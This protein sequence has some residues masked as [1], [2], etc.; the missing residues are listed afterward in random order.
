LASTGPGRAPLLVTPRGQAWT[1]DDLG[2]RV[3]ALLRGV[4]GRVVSMHSLRHG[5]ATATLLRWGV[6]E[7]RAS[8]PDAWGHA[9]VA[10]PSLA[11]VQLALGDDD[12]LVLHRLSRICGHAAPGVTV[13]HYL[14]MDVVQDAWLAESAPVRLRSSVAADLLQCSAPAMYQHLRPVEHGWVGAEDVLRAQL[15]RLR[16][17]HC[18]SHGER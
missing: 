17:R 16:H 7:G 6:A 13:A 18:G 9:A 4:T 15:T 8:W 1:P 5:F 3:A 14:A 2:R 11:G 12:A 10:P